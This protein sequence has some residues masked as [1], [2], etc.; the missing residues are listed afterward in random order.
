MGRGRLRLVVVS[1]DHRRVLARPNGLAGWALPAIAADLPFL[2]WDDETL[3]SA[4]AVVGADLRPLLDLGDRTWAL[5]PLGRVAA[6]GN[7]WI[8]EQDL[9]RLG[10]DAVVA[11]AWFSHAR[12]HDEG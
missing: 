4:R 9:A 7:T 11:Q 12:R 10:N 6:P 5:E 2:G 8:G 1:P 3:G